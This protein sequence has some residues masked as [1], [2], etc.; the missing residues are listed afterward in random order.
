MAM[1]N[2]FGWSINPYCAQAAARII[3]TDSTAMKPALARRFDL[4]VSRLS[5]DSEHHSG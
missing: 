2:Q 4:L 5:D 1:W 3:A